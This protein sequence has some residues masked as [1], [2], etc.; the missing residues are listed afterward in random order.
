MKKIYE[1]TGHCSDCNDVFSVY[2]HQQPHRQT[3][4]YRV[5]PSPYLVVRGDRI[6]HLHNACRGRIQLFGF[7]PR[8]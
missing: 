6:T 8:D 5:E 7:V 4:S 3:Y 2:L 1:V